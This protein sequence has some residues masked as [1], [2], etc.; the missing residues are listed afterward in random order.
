MSEAADREARKA[1]LLQLVEAQRRE[2][3]RDAALLSTNVGRVDG[4]L[5]IAR[6]MTPAVAV[7]LVAV[8]AA[9]GPSRVG[10]WL[11]TA[12]VP[13]WLIRQFLSFRR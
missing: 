3:S 9:A 1:E 11:R 5:A 13:I 12:V 4:W 2:L 7:G 10:R 6:R 8:T